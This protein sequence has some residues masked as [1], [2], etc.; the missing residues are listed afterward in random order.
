MSLCI[1]RFD[2]FQKEEVGCFNH[3]FVNFT[4]LVI[5]FGTSERRNFQL[6]GKS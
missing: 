5:S 2:P 4:L 6:E 1:I 3:V